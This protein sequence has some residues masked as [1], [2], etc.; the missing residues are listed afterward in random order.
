MHHEI[1]NHGS[2]DDRVHPD[3]F[4]SYC[5]H[6]SSNIDSDAF[7]ELMMSNVWGLNAPQGGGMPFAGS[8]RKITKVN[9][10]ESYRSDHHRNLFHTDV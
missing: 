7:F 10:R 5:S 9:A 4:I 6:V 8:S 3:E 2:A 1:V